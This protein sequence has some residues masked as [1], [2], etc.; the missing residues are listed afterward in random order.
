MRRFPAKG[1]AVLAALASSFGCGGGGGEASPSADLILRG[2]KI[3][4]LDPARPEAEALA[5]RDGR[6]V[7]VGTSQEI[8]KLRGPATEVVELEGRLAIPGFIEGHGHFVGLGHSLLIVDLRDARSWHEVVE[9][10]AKAAASAAPDAWIEGRGWHQEKWDAPPEPAVEGYPLHDELSA[11]VPDHPVVLVHASGHASLVNARA[12]ELAAIGADTPDP[13]GGEILRDARGRATGLL[14]ENAEDLVARA[15]DD[16]QSRMSPEARESAVRHEIE[17]ASF[18]CLRKG[19]TSFQDAGSSFETIER[20]RRAAEAGALGPRLWVMLNEDDDAIVNAGAAY[21]LVGAAGDRLTVRAIKRYFDGALGSHGAWL[22]E[23]YA[24]LPASVGLNTLPVES[25]AA[26]A[27][28]ALERGLQLCVHAIGDRANREALDV[29]AAAFAGKTDATTGGRELR[30][31]IEHAQ[32]IDPADIPRFAELGVI[33]SMQAVHCTSDGPWVPERLGAARA[34]AGA[35]MWR[36]LLDSG[37]VVTNGTDTPVEDVDPIANFHAAVTRRMRNGEAF[38]PAQ[39]MT[40]DEALHAATLGA[41]Y[42]AFEE[43]V[44]GSLAPGKLA[45]VVVLS[46]DILTVPDDEIPGTEVLATIVGGEV[47]YRKGET[48]R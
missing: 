28:V 23:P 17:E 46:R 8:E 26:T 37:A 24:D 36:A 1:L 15:R 22:L 10:A 3:V 14:R 21:P 34:E 6:I 35:Y 38:Y 13:A 44:K 20:L 39:R 2:G 11:A 45:D 31:R 40:R 16:A 33:A 47:V 42:A 43:D 29:F 5:A 32:H 41:A 25:L 4:T 30:W 7:A 48:S 19:V 27:R 12:M 18:E 9:R